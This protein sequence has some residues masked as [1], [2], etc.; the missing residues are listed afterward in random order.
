MKRK[1]L[2]ILLVAV[3]IATILAATV[4]PSF[5]WS[6]EYTE[7][8][9]S[10]TNDTWVCS[11]YPVYGDNDEVLHYTFEA[12]QISSGASSSYFAPSWGE[13]KDTLIRMEFFISGSTAGTLYVTPTGSTSRQW[14]Y[15]AFYVYEDYRYNCYIDAWLSGGYLNF[16]YMTDQ[17]NVTEAD[18][19][20]R[21]IMSP[22]YE[23]TIRNIIPTLSEDLAANYGQIIQAQRNEIA[24]LNAQVEGLREENAGLANNNVLD[25]ALTGIGQGF[26]AFISPL[27][28]I[29]V[30]GVT[31]G[32]ICAVL[33][34]I[35]LIMLFVIIFQ[36]I[37]GG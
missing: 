33:L 17:P 7:D 11:A 34:F 6:L 8:G 12:T 27:L 18:I 5:A 19:T 36:K 2:K 20:C 15:N 23:Y 21:V 24:S 1:I 10:V 14:E 3:S 26:G 25:G 22:D 32:T 29:G 9:V 30:G 28:D 13:W 16:A 31:V 37:R 4:V 35:G